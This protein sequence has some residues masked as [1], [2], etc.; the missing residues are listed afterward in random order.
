MR[1]PSGNCWKL[2][3]GLR[4]VRFSRPMS[5]AA[6][7]ADPGAPAPVSRPAYYPLAA[8]RATELQLPCISAGI[9]AL[10][11]RRF[12]QSATSALRH[13]PSCGPGSAV[14]VAGRVTRRHGHW[15]SMGGQITV[16]RHAPSPDSAGTSPTWARSAGNG[17]A[18]TRNPGDPGRGHGGFCGPAAG[19]SLT[20]GWHADGLAVRPRAP[21]DPAARSPYSAAMPPAGGLPET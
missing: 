14:V 1:R 21:H 6:A 11:M 7:T 3:S 20:R 19:E 10:M 13:V 16:S 15:L 12:P 4:P 5:R 2:A 8:N 9:C 17:R 18:V